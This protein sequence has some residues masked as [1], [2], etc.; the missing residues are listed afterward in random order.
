MKNVKKLCLTLM[1]LVILT[2]CSEVIENDSA[3]SRSCEYATNTDAENWAEE[4]TQELLQDGEVAYTLQPK[5][6]F[7]GKLPDKYI[8]QEGDSPTEN[9]DGTLTVLGKTYNL[10]EANPV[11]NYGWKVD[12]SEMVRRL[13]TNNYDI[14]LP[15]ASDTCICVVDHSSN[16]ILVYLRSDILNHSLTEEDFMRFDFEKTSSLPEGVTAQELWNFHT[17]PIENVLILPIIDDP[18]Q[19]GVSYYS[20][21]ECNALRYDI[22]WFFHRNELYVYNTE[23]NEIIGQIIQ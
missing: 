22:G 12:L 13:Q 6:P 23:K 21:L 16:C 10:V 17:A 20:F 19:Q 14:L 9:S 1:L 7:F 8:D 3:D 4:N 15:E 11:Y 18:P 2:A 5:E